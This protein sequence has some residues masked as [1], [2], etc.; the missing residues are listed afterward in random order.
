M[1]KLEWLLLQQDRVSGRSLGSRTKLVCSESHVFVHLRGSVCSQ[2]GDLLLES[3]NLCCKHFCI[4][5]H[6][7]SSQVNFWRAALAT[8]HRSVEL[9]MDELYTVF[10]DGCSRGEL[11]LI[12]VCPNEA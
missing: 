11:Q 10:V 5:C 1:H 6:R 3:S 7:L 2:C 9:S 4:W 12:S 8:E